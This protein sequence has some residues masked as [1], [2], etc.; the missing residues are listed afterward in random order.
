[1]ELHGS[2]VSFFLVTLTFT[3]SSSEWVTSWWININLLYLLLWFS[4]LL[5]PLIQFPWPDVMG[6]MNLTTPAP[7]RSITLHWVGISECNEASSSQACRRAF[8]VTFGISAETR[9]RSYLADTAGRLVR[10]Q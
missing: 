10:K 1:M 8:K 7:E 5:V 3:A 2:L 9:S 4:A 6:L